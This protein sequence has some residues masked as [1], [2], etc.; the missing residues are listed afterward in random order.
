MQGRSA[1]GFVA[2]FTTWGRQVAREEEADGP[3][4]KRVIVPFQAGG[5]DKNTKAKANVFRRLKE[6]TPA[7]HANL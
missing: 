6:A 5:S 1:R 4:R 3:R 7:T 2:T